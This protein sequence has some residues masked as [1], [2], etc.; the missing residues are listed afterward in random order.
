VVTEFA[1]LGLIAGFLAAFF[2]TLIAW[3]LSREVFELPF[4]INPSLWLFG[5]VG[6]ALGIS[7]AGYLA[8]RRVLHTPPIVALRNTA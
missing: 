5:V 3:A 4:S 8:T 6:G 7:I 1:I 2:A